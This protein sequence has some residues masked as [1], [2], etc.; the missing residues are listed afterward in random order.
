[1]QNCNRS[2][3]ISRLHASQLAFPYDALVQFNFDPH[4]LFCGDALEKIDEKISSRMANILSWIA[5]ALLGAAAAVV[6][7]LLV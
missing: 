4:R 5:A 6:L 3:G 1:M 7:A 2:G